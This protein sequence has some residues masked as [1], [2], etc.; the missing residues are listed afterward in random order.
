MQELDYRNRL[1]IL[2]YNPI[3][4]GTRQ[5]LVH[6]ASQEE[7]AAQLIKRLRRIRNPKQMQKLGSVRGTSLKK[8]NIISIHTVL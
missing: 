5:R 6:D 1:I 2:M 3:L 4:V 7:D 8:N